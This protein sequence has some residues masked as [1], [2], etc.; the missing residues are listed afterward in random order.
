MNDLATVAT[1]QLPKFVI[2]LLIA[3]MLGFGGYFIYQN[4]KSNSSDNETT[5][6]V[7]SNGYNRQQYQFY[8]YG[9]PVARCSGGYYPAHNSNYSHNHGCCQQN[10][11]TSSPTCS[12]TRF[13]WQFSQP[14]KNIPEAMPLLQKGVRFRSRV[15]VFSQ[16]RLP[17]WLVL[18]LPLMT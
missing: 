13:W 5:E 12:Y 9:C 3:A 8:G 10:S 17:W 4:S 14:T 7:E 2:G 16:V 18:K 6:S 11:C 15:L 1:T